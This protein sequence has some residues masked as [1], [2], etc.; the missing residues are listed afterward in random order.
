MPARLWWIALCESTVAILAIV[1]VSLVIPGQ[2]GFLALAPHPLWFA[3]LAIAAR[4][5]GSAG[6]TAG[7]LAAAAYALLLWARPEAPFAPLPERELIQPILLFVT[8]V[9][10]SEIVRGPRQRAAQAEASRARAEAQLRELAQRHEAILE[11][12]AELESQLLDQSPS[13]ACLLE[14][15]RGLEAR[16][17]VERE[18]SA[19]ELIAGLLDASACALY[20]DDGDALRLSA[21]WPSGSC[22][23]PDV[24]VPTPN[25]VVGEVLV[26]QQ[27]VTIRDRILATDGQ[28]GASLSPVMAGPLLDERGDLFG[29]VV[30]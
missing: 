9:A 6:Y 28:P 29:V 15:A 25:S 7:A 3:A 11:V 13:L 1:A 8:T 2:W 20:V 30:I 4:Y 23:G 24:L 14:S 10:L 18:R 5:G 16:R 19:L 21:S 12:K 22:P 27:V 17:S 26:T